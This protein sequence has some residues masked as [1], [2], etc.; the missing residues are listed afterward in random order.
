[1]SAYEII[2][3]NAT[4]IVNQNAPAGTV[5]AN[6]IVE[7]EGLSPITDI[8]LYGISAKYF[9]IDMDGVIKLSSEAELNSVIKS[10]YSLEVIATTSDQDSNRAVVDITV[11]NTDLARI[12]NLS[13]SIDENATAGTIVGII[14]VIDSGSSEINS[15]S[16]TGIGSHDFSVDSTGVIRLAESVSLDFDQK[17]LYNLKSYAINNSGNSLA[18]EAIITVKEI[19]NITAVQLPLVLIAISF[20]D[21]PIGDS[22]LNWHNKTFGNAYGQINHY[23]K[24][25]SNGTFSIV[26][27]QESSGTV[28][29]GIMKVSLGINHPGNNSM[30]RAHLVDAITMTDADINYA[31]YDT[32]GNGHIEVDELQI[33]FIVGGGET[34]FGDPVASST[35]AHASGVATP[36]ILDGVTVMSYYENG[37]Y[38][39]FGER[40]G[41]HFATI[42]VI[43]HELGHAMFGLPDLY[44]RDQSSGGIGYFCL[45]ASGSWSSKSGENSGATPV[46][47]SAWAKIE[48]GL[49]TPEVITDTTNSITMHA[50]HRN[51]YNI[52][53]I[54]TDNPDEYFLVE[55]R[56]PIGYD[57]GMYKL[58]YSEFH[59]GVAIWHIDDSQSATQNDDE[60]HKQVDLEEAINPELD[61]GGDGTGKNLFYYGNSILFDEVSSPNSKKYDGTSSNI[62]VNNISAI[63]SVNNDYAMTI[64]V[65]R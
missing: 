63:G 8:Q 53:K 39:R 37:S 50:T 2:L 57:A 13:N 60:T 26:P 3:G 34:A 32:N 11:V 51:E 41:N 28:D 15:F 19:G 64:D 10:L 6:I 36:P 31:Q 29:D 22:A 38:S 65:Q 49:L 4:G 61:N 52:V 21:Y 25:I 17:D 47:M 12:E 54:P 30:N 40:Q 16:L 9:D 1:M 56:S 55:N 46:H 48:S 58:D 42:G 18:A 35:W 43:V 14:E 7:Q 59:G 44:D 20:N 5:V 27:A 45:M 33:M 23:Y 62:K 24:E